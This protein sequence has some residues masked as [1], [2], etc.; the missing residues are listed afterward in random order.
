MAIL[1]LKEQEH[2]AAAAGAP[3]HTELAGAWAEVAGGR[4]AGACS[5]SC[6]AYG[7]A[8]GRHSQISAFPPA[9]FCGCRLRG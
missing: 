5:C 2:A 1:A 3:L 9:V 7:R 8:R 6:V 4:Q